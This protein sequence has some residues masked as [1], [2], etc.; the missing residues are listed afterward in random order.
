MSFVL[1]RITSVEQVRVI[2]DAERAS[3]DYDTL[4]YAKNH[5]LFADAWAVD[6]EKDCYLLRAP[7]V[8][9]EDGEN[10]TYYFYFKGELYKFYLVGW[11]GGEVRF[12][13]SSIS[14]S[15]LPS[16]FKGAVTAAFAV[17]GES[18]SGPL[19][20]FGNPEFAI[21]PIFKEGA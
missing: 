16:G 1:E 7:R 2:N 20:Q 17:Y 3:L 11:F 15:S 12:N 10:R 21:S 9:R 4:V 5:Q 6:K 13:D 14:L 19:N 8:M 18:G